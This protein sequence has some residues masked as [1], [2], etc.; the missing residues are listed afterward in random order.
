MWT[1]FDSGA[2]NTYIVADCVESLAA[3]DI[4]EPQPSALGGRTHVVTRECLLVGRVNGY[5]VSVDARIVAEI[6]R[7]EE[8]KRIEV[9][10]GALAMQKYGINVDTKNEKLDFTHYPKEFVEF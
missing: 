9:I 3:S 6:G 4:P 1:L 7:D 5:A 8:D 10:F 2:R